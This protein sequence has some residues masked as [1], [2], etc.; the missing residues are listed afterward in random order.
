MASLSPDQVAGYLERISLP[1]QARAWLRE[2]PDGPHAL[3]A[4]TQLQQHHMAAV[5]FD[6][7]ELHYSTH[8]GTLPQ[9]TD[10][11]YETVVTRRRGGT[12]PQVHQLFAKLLRALGF[13]AY[14]TGARL[15]APASPAADPSL[16]DKSKVVYGPWVHVATLVH[17]P[18]QTTPSSS[19]WYL[20]DTNTGP[21]GT[22]YPLPLLHNQPTTCHDMA[23]RQRRMLH[24]PVPNNM[25]ADPH[26]PWWRMQLRED[27]KSE[28]MDVCCFVEAEWKPVDFQIMIAGLGTLGAGWFQARV[29]CYRVILEAGVPVG[30]LMAWQDELRR[31]YKGK[32]EVVQRF[33]CEADRVAA[34]EEEFGVVLTLEEQGAIV[35]RETELADVGGEFYG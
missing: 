35:G 3:E 30:Y 14:C 13:T 4:L 33:Y 1:A 18:P 6:N 10:L 31:W 7:L 23:P 8:N 21:F 11:V 29:V 15:N 22:P 27:T 25:T 28:W 16:V 24:G 5:P 17:L 26:Q 19:C 20:I 9:E 12:C 32:M 34:L 2:G